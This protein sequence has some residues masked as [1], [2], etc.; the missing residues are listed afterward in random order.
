MR[1]NRLTLGRMASLS[2]KTD[3][4][5]QTTRWRRSYQICEKSV[6]LRKYI[7]LWF[8]KDV[9]VKL[10]IFSQMVSKGVSTGQW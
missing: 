8:L 6:Y 4:R 2:A 1:Q 10:L 9:P 7:S 5:G 3:Y